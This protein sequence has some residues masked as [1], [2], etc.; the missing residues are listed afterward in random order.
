[1][2]DYFRELTQSWADTDGP[3]IVRVAQVESHLLTV[4]GILD[5][6]R[7]ALNGREVNLTLTSDH[8][9]VLGTISAHAAAIS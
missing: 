9:P 2:K 5:V 8:I 3:L 1:M 6:G 7:T 4:P